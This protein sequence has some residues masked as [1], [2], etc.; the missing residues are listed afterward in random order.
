MQLR[1]SSI[2]KTAYYYEPIP[3][4]AENLMYMELID[5]EYMEKPFYGSRQ[6]TAVLK[7]LGYQVNRK[8]IIRL[9]R[10][11]GIEAIFPRKNL[12]KPSEKR[13]KYPY[14]LKG[15][16]IHA[17][18]HVWATDITY[19][20]ISGGFLHLVAIIDW[21][22]R[23]VLSWRLSNTMDI[24]FC[25]EAL[26][27]AMSNRVPKIFNSDQGSQFT[28]K[29]F[30]QVL[31]DHSV[32]ISMDS[33]GRAFDNIIIERL[34][35]TVKYEEVYIKRYETGLEAFNGL[36]KYI[37]FYNEQRPHSSLGGRTP[38]EIYRKRG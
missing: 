38:A 34:W 31:K 25:L 6:I 35:R 10:T 7:R 23:Y 8:R 14:L 33:R 2:S 26:L 13:E 20:P 36:K 32:Q 17:P 19:I 15:I 11:M 24:N 4:T 9:M 5:R 18:D 27:E 1:L 28:S 3:E 16:E 21:F 37:D 22:T 29:E 30:Q 12:S